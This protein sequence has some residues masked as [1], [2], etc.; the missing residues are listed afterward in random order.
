L[1]IISKSLAMLIMV[2]MYGSMYIVY[3]VGCCQFV[4]VEGGFQYCYPG[5]ST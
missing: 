1:N 3:D 2:S 4:G 5:H